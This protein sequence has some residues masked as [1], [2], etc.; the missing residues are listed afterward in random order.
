MPGNQITN[1]TNEII[2]P[3]VRAAW[4]QANTQSFGY[5]LLQQDSIFGNSILPVLPR[6]DNPQQK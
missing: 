4:N 3:T 5:F 2:N 6:F 1:Q